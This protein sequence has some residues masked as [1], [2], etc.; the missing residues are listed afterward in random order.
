MQLGGPLRFHSFIFW[1]QRVRHGGYQ[2]TVHQ[3]QLGAGQV[4]GRQEEALDQVPGAG[5][6]EDERA[7][8]IYL[9]GWV[10]LETGIGGL[11]WFLKSRDGRI[12]VQEVK[13]RWVQGHSGGLHTCIMPNWKLYNLIWL[14]GDSLTPGNATTTTTTAARFPNY[15][16]DF[17]LVLV[18]SAW[19][20]NLIRL[21]L[22]EIVITHRPR[23]SSSSLR[24]ISAECDKKCS[25]YIHLMKLEGVWH[26][27]KGDY[28]TDKSPRGILICTCEWICCIA[29]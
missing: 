11:V 3:L 23:S 10:E 29:R 4:S 12:V 13:Q 14:V 18:V 2:G 15:S 6:G 27:P 17:D 20:H 22:I 5:R 1:I 28:T 26:F 9:F 19:M 7:A 24:L 25:L 16:H 21:V 8:E